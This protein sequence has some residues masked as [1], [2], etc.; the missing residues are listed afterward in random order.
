MPWKVCSSTERSILNGTDTSDT[1][2]IPHPAIGPKGDPS[3]RGF[4]GSAGVQGAP[5]ARG[6]KGDPGARGF[7]GSA[8]VCPSN[9]RSLK[10]HDY[11]LTPSSVEGDGSSK[12]SLADVEPWML[13]FFASCGV[14]LVSTGLMC[15]YVSDLK[16][17]VRKLQNQIEGKAGMT[18]AANRNSWDMRKILSNVE[19]NVE[20]RPIN[21]LSESAIGLSIGRELPKPVVTE[22]SK[23]TRRSLLTIESPIQWIEYVDKSTKKPYYH[24]SST[25][26]TQWEKPDVLFGPVR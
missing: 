6:P 9:C 21:S 16:I 5:G 3:A 12:S 13:A 26:A 18:Q 15:K 7:N 8:G 14:M 2:C 10:R 24:N 22:R 25:G 4:N 1:I 11:D 20:M 19:H 23:P 17:T